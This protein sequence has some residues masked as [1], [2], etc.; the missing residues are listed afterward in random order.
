MQT[1]LCKKCKSPC[2]LIV[3]GN[4]APRVCPYGSKANWVRTGLNTGPIAEQLEF[5]AGKW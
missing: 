3:E 5:L 4:D 2:F 1:Y